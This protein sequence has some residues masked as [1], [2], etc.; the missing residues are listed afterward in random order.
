[1]FMF[2][3]C[4]YMTGILLMMFVTSMGDMGFKQEDIL[5]SFQVR[6][7]LKSEKNSQLFETLVNFSG[8]EVTVVDGAALQ[9]GVTDINTDLRAA[10]GSSFCRAVG[11]TLDVGHG[12]SDTGFFG[13][14]VPG[15]QVTRHNGFVNFHVEELLGGQAAG[16]AEQAVVDGQISDFR[17]LI[18]FDTR[19]CARHG[20]LLMLSS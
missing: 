13:H 15:N 7:N 14:W 4:P 20:V 9:Q 12:C 8:I 16:L 10:I 6:L 18:D 17:A 19:D 5:L 1:M 11:H 2:V 3:I